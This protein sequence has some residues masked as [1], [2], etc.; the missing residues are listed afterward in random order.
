HL[1]DAEAQVR[2]VFFRHKARF[3]DFALKDGLQVEVRATPTLYEPKGEFQLEVEVVRLAGLGILYE[4]FAQLK[5]RLE[6]AG[7]FAEERKRPLPR[8]PRAVGIITSVAAAALRD[9]LTTLNRRW[10]GMRVILYPSAVQGP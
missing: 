8:F 9:V 3:A 10:P 4:R 6:A 1:K 2:C 7:W 5:A